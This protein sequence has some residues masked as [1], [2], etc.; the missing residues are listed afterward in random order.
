MPEVEP[1]V[2]PIIMEH[3]VRV[4]LDPAGLS[5]DPIS[6]EMIEVTVDFDTTARLPRRIKQAFPDAAEMYTAVTWKMPRPA[7]AEEN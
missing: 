3:L 6:D 7:A 1:G 5:V 2:G 4:G